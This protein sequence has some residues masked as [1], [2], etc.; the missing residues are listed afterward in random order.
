MWPKGQHFA[1]C[2]VEPSPKK[3]FLRKTAPSRLLQGPVMLCELPVLEPRL[4][5]DQAW[6]RWRDGRGLGGG[7]GGGELGLC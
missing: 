7:A 6:M 1:M 2:N 5:K 3:H 4:E